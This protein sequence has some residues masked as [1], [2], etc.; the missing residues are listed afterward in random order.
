[1]DRI[2]HLADRFE[3]GHLIFGLF[4]ML[5]KTRLDLGGRY[6]FY[7]FGKCSDDLLFGRIK[8]L[9]LVDQ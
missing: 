1:M 9:Q 5:R 8:I 3:T 2:P 4:E 7:D 6:R